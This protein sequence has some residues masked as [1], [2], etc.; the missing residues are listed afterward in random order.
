MK[1]TIKSSSAEHSGI[2]V[3]DFKEAEN[4]LQELAE[5][6]KEKELSFTVEGKVSFQYI[7]GRKFFD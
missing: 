4:K 6:D 1:L 2:E 7:V 5:K 3:K